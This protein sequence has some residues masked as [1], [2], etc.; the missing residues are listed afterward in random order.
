MTC[1]CERLTGW[2]ERMGSGGP[3]WAGASHP[4]PVGALLA[5]VVL[6][7]RRLG[8]VL[9]GRG[10]LRACSSLYGGSI[11]GVNLAVS[12]LVVTHAVQLSTLVVL[13]EIYPAIVVRVAIS[14][15]P[16][17]ERLHCRPARMARSVSGTL[18][19]ATIFDF[20]GVTVE[21]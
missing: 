4:Q 8:G 9:G 21:R 10:L 5:L 16:K 12:V 6:L 14:R 11:P 18:S 2:G 1:D 17:M 15:S 7:L 19:R 13:P 20:C 3:F